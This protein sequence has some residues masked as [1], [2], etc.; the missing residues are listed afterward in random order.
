MDTKENVTTLFN[1]RVKGTVMKS[2]LFIGITLVMILVTQTVM[3]DTIYV[4]KTDPTSIYY[5]DGDRD[6]VQINMA[7]RDANG[8]LVL[9][10]PG[11]YNLH[12]Q[13]VIDKSN[14]T[15]RGAG[16][17]LSILR[18]IDNGPNLYGR[19]GIVRAVSPDR[20][21]NAV[22]EDLMIDGNSANNPD[23]EHNLKQMGIYM[24]CDD[25]RI[26][27]VTV[28]NIATCAINPHGRKDIE[29]SRNIIVEYSEA[30]NN[31]A[32]GLTVDMGVGSIIRYNYLHHNGR[33]GLHFTGEWIAAGI[34]T[35]FAIAHD[36][37]IEYNTN[38]VFIGKHTTDVTLENNI[39][40][41]NDTYGIDA[42]ELGEHTFAGNQIYYN[43]KSGIRVRSPDNLIENNILV[44]N[45]K[46]TTEEIRFNSGVYTDANGDDH[47]YFPT[48]NIVRNNIIYTPAKWAALE[49]TGADNNEFSNNMVNSNGEVAFRILGANSTEINTL[50]VPVDFI[51]PPPPEEIIPP[52]NILGN[53]ISNF[54]FE[55]GTTNWVV[56]EPVNIISVGYSGAKSLHVSE[57]TSKVTQ[58]I[59]VEPDTTYILSGKVRSN[60]VIGIITETGQEE[61][62]NTPRYTWDDVTYQFT[63]SPTQ[64]EVTIFAGY[65]A[66][67]TEGYVD[68]IVLLM[69]NIPSNLL[70]K[71]VSSGMYARINPTNDR[72]IFDKTIEGAQGFAKQAKGTGIVIW[73]KGGSYDGFYLLEPAGSSR[74]EAIATFEEA[75]I[76]AEFPCV[77]EGLYFKSQATNKSV[78]L[79]R[80]LGLSNGSSGTCSA[81]RNKFIWEGNDSNSDDTE[82]PSEPLDLTAETITASTI[83]LSWT[84]STD[85]VGVI[86]YRILENGTEIGSTSTTNFQ[87]TGLLEDTEF[88]Y[89]VI[90]YDAAE[91]ES[92][93]SDISCSVT[94]EEM[95]Y[96]L[97]HV[98]G[99]YIRILS[100]TNELIADAIME[101]AQAF[102]KV[103]KG[104]GF[105]IKAVRGVYNGMYSVE[106]A[107]SSR[108]SAVGTYDEAETFIENSC[109]TGEFY[110]TSL[111]TSKSVKVEKNLKLG[112]GSSISCGR[113]TTFTWEPAG[114]PI[115]DV[116]AP[117]API[118]DNSLI[119]TNTKVSLSWQ[120]STD[121]VGVTSYMINV[122]MG[123]V[124]EASTSV[125]PPLLSGTVGG[126]TT[127][128]TYSV[129]VV[130][131]DA[132][133]NETASEPM[134]FTTTD[135]TTESYALLTHDGLYGAFDSGSGK[136]SGTEGSASTAAAFEI[137]P[138]GSGYKLKIA[139]SNEYAIV[140]NSR[141]FSGPEAEAAV[142][143]SVDASGGWNFISSGG[144]RLKD[145]QDEIGVNSSASNNVNR[146]KFVA[147]P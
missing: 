64:T 98:S 49:R 126:L 18:F 117:T 15:L 35:G 136:L 80:N 121:D 40:R 99:D 5:S 103:S 132:A 65:G 84:A 90:S 75:E 46:M 61:A 22:I 52:G 120:A 138:E 82:S 27:R 31:G 106:P 57:P 58:T 38:G 92:M 83:A 102:E 104:S 119:V 68:D 39:I 63:T 1:P 78:K 42:R 89:T 91:N 122:S 74:Q 53:L 23:P 105:A 48:G 17:T 144:Q 20:L 55:E 44:N 2:K 130:A 113:P 129:E 100:E 118:I 112:N 10:D 101:D 77:D 140:N 11:T 135:A 125:I 142:F 43:T 8:G 134:D 26:S 3:A 32:D 116:E 19:T 37:I 33:N 21:N 96:L 73:V 56:D 137:I 146:F 85:N 108:Q 111:V 93:E 45:A 81:T 88:C 72:V 36:N 29:P 139:G 67:S 86:G 47:P 6:E 145:M 34:E 7:I 60:A 131:S 94:F 123:G 54:S 109:D 16:Q 147:I 141:I 127:N 143:S 128:T 28:K 59:T 95:S 51:L 50:P 66:G 41:Y 30:F 97:K 14:T 70:L 62:T 133:G 25:C 79:E 12:D 114:E 124:I 76:F 115:I 107:G 87:H 71:H 9:L 13:V 24:E 69:V 4:S 110:L